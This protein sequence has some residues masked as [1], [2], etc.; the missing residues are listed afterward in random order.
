MSSYALVKAIEKATER[1]RRSKTN[2]CV[3][4]IDKGDEREIDV[5]PER[6]VHY[7]EFE[8][9]SGRVLVDVFYDNGMIFADPKGPNCERQ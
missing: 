6:Y 9:F 3:V 4:E 2:Y 7:D 5:V 8:A 1:C